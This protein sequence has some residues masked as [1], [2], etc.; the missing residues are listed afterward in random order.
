[1]PAGDFQA[2]RHPAPGDALDLADRRVALS[3]S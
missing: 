1:V 2:A 3:S